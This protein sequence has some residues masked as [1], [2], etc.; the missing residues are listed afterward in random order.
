MSLAHSVNMRLV[1]NNQ[2]LAFL[3]NRV[4]GKNIFDHMNRKMA[5]PRYTPNTHGKGT[6]AH[7]FTGVSG[8]TGM[9]STSGGFMNGYT[10]DP[11]FDDVPDAVYYEESDSDAAEQEKAKEAAAAAV[12]NKFTKAVIKRRREVA[13]GAGSLLAAVIGSY[14]VIA[15]CFIAA[16]GDN[17]GVTIASVAFG[18]AL[19]LLTI[20]LCG[21]MA[22]I[23]A[24]DMVLNVI[25][26]KMKHWSTSGAIVLDVLSVILGFVGVFY[27]PA[28][29]TIAVVTD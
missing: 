18:S 20:G 29:Y 26:I 2:P 8:S 10:N 25:D 21:A 9:S 24:F 23:G 14:I 6:G 27:L 1:N 7:I 4:N 3:Y 11:V 12:L 13:I 28:F 5:E 22:F 16:C 19:Y 15:M 17:L